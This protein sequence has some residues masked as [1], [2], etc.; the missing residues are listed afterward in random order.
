MSKTQYGVVE[1]DAASVLLRFQKYEAVV[2]RWLRCEESLDECDMD[3]WPLRKSNTA[4]PASSQ[5]QFSPDKVRYPSY[6]FGG[7]LDYNKNGVGTD[8]RKL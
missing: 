7:V 2:D 3:G 1:S 8:S 4:T 5:Q 6:V